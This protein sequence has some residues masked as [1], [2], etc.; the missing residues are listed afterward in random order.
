MLESFIKAH[1]WDEA[2]ILIGPGNFEEGLKAPI[3]HNA[4]VSEEKIGKDT[5]QII[6]NS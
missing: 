6:Y 5:L 2:R 1:L 4:I 3:L